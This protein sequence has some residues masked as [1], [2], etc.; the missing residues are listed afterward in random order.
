MSRWLPLAVAVS[1]GCGGGG[2]ILLEPRHNYAFGGRLDAVVTELEAQTDVVFDW[3]ELTTDLRER[4]LGA[5]GGV[6]LLGCGA[7]LD[8]VLDQ[9]AANVLYSSTCTEGFVATPAPGATEVRASDFGIV[10]NPLPVADTLL[11]DDRTWAVALTGAEGDELLF[12]A[13]VRF[14]EGAEA[15]RLILTPDLT[16]AEVTVSLSGTPLEARRGSTVLDWSA[17]LD[18]E[19][20]F[21]SSFDDV[22]ADQLLLARFDVEDVSPLEAD[23]LPLD[24]VAAELYRTSVL[25]E[26][27]ADLTQA[28]DAEG[29]PFTGFTK[30][31]TWL[32]GLGC[33]TCLHPA[34]LVLAVV[35]VR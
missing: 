14:G 16:R 3:S 31:G 25:G 17:F 13:F 7:P 34:P 20:A 29:N 8:E 15:T 1:L 21:G 22:R 6:G 30:G 10:G 11:E 26:T 9:L 18:G 12:L 24:E 33:T 35:R 2:P 23:F 32:V 28:V 19:D 5:V 27:R 4:P